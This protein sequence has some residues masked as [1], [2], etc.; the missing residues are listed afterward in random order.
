ME[1]DLQEAVRILKSGGIILYPTDTIW[2]LGCD[3]TNQEAV[4]KLFAL[5]KRPD[6]KAMISLVDSVNS[7]SGWVRKIPSAAVQEF[8]LSKTPVTIVLDSPVG[9][10]GLL[11]AT[12]GSSAFRIPQLEFTRL[13][14]FHLGHP[15]VSTSPNISSSPSPRSF[16]D[17]SEEIVSGVDYVCEYGRDLFGSR[18][19][20]IVKITNDNRI[21]V[22]RE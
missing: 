16:G 18:P 20:R 22:I 1:K 15:I 10:S 6:S 5:K 19:S 11:K 21:F 4:E 17:I 2:G 14:C 12:D 8:S 7:L 3:A 13:L 9:I